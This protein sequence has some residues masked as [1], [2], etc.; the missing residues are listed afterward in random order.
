MKIKK[1]DIVQIMAGEEAGKKGKILKVFP[2][3][4]KIL[5]EGIN[6]YKKHKKPRKQGEKGEIVT[7][8]RSVSIANAALY[9]ENCG[10]GMRV[11]KKRQC[12]KCKSTL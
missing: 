4:N 8:P 7:V 10:K 9:C 12:L 6:L 5:V 3:S 2:E 11:N 1:G